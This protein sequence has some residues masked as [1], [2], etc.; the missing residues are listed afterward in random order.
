M[1]TLECPRNIQAIPGSP[2]LENPRPSLW[3]SVSSLAL[4]F[5]PLLISCTLARWSYSW[6]CLTIQIQY[7][8]PAQTLMC[9]SRLR[10]LKTTSSAHQIYS[11]WNYI[12]DYWYLHLPISR[13]S[14]KHEKH[15]FYLPL[16]S[17]SH[18]PN[19]LLPTPVNFK[20]LITLSIF[21]NKISGKP[22]GNF[23]EEGL[24]ASYLFT[25]C[26]ALCKLRVQ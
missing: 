16:F 25:N 3:D 2:R 1:K 19:Q 10:C 4:S 17:L 20:P 24:T 8:S 21:T 26:T 6:S 22:F 13:T 5:Y 18:T 7:I 12:L 14:H 15:S 9:S 23:Y 11:Y